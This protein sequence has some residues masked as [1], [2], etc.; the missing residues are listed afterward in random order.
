M[1]CK[2]HCGISIAF[3]SASAYLML[4]TG[5][6]KGYYK[7][8]KINQKKMYRNVVNERR[9][10]WLKSTLIAIIAALG[11][12]FYFRKSG[13]NNNLLACENTA[14]YFLVQ[15][16]VYSL[17]PK[18][19]W[20]LNSLKTRKEIDGWVEKYQYMKTKWHIGLILGLVGYFLYSYVLVKNTNK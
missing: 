2:T 7:N 4:T 14:I 11:Y 5:S 12:H 1:K 15:Y 19:N 9:N 8:L 18:K 6:K 20:I 13:N 10:I 17:H 3:L 16:F